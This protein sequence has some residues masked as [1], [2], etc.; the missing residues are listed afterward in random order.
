M[1]WAERCARLERMDTET[2]E[3]ATATR[4]FANLE[5]I[6]RY[7]GGVRATLWH[8]ER[9]ARRWRPGDLIRIVDWGTGGA[10]MPR[11]LV[12]WGRRRGFRLHILGIDQDPA[13]VAYARNACRD[14]PEIAIINADAR[15]FLPGA[16]PVD[17]AISSLTLHHLTDDA[18]LDLLRTSDRLVRR[19]LVMNDLRRSIRAWGWIWALSRAARWHPMVRHDGPLSVRRAFA[20]RDLDRYAQQTGLSYL[21]TRAH[22]GHRL[23]LAGEKA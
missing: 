7:L 8:F 13:T 21:K 6:N 20:P 1:I 4:V 11:A 3:P 23:T 14:Y 9:F 10:D 2:L 22:F 15:L 12:R 19:G 17:Y 18:I 16:E 5:T